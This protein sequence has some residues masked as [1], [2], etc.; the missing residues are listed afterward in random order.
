MKFDEAGYDVPELLTMAAD[1]LIALL[2][3]NDSITESDQI[4]V[5]S[6]RKAA[7]EFTCQ[8]ET[9]RQRQLEADRKAGAE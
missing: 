9:E 7:E 4:L 8:A 1:R 5:T 3:P 6:L 2:P